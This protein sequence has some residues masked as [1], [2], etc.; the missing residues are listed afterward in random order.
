ME[1]YS[2]T[3]NKVTF[4][5]MNDKK[6][7]LSKKTFAQ[8]LSI[9]NVEP[10]YKVMNEQIIH[11]FNKMGHQPNLTKMSDFKKPGLPCIWNFFFG[12]Y[13]RCLTGR[14]VGLDKGRLEVYA[15]VAS[16]YYDLSVD[17]ATQL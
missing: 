7:R 9:P 1:T 6:F 17:Y 10:F 14:T 12:I 5:I 8:I 4:Q 3:M 13:L 15:M 11:V 2:K 16:L